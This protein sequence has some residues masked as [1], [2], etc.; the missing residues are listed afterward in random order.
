LPVFPK[1]ADEQNWRDL[2]ADQIRRNGQLFFRLADKI[3]RNPSASEDVVQQ[4]MLKACERQDELRNPQSLR[5]W[6]ARMVVNESLRVVRRRKSERGVL[7]KQA[8]S[9][10]V[11][12]APTDAEFELCD[13]VLRALEQ[14]TEPMRMVVVLRHMQKLPGKEVSQILGMSESEVSKHLQ[15]GS[16]ILRISLGDWRH[17]NE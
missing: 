11:P 17:L 16:E 9:L 4:A 14:L 10:P 15:R 1:S 12:M 2:L 7:A 5:S 8:A 6:L 13:S 3:L